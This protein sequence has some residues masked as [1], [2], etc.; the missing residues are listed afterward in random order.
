LEK[1]RQDLQEIG[2]DKRGER[3][4]S[5]EWGSIE[6]A[7]RKNVFTLETFQVDTSPEEK[8]T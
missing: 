3:N 6:A 7:R 8:N 1:G 4:G 2:K 5:L